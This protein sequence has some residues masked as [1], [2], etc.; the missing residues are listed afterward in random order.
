MKKFIRSFVLLFTVCLL[1]LSFSSVCA[2]PTDPPPV[3]DHGQNG[4]DP[5][6]APIDGGV[7]ILLL[8]G[9]GYAARK[10]YSVKKEKAE[11]VS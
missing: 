4:G 10:L 7:G 3:P 11:V 8:M 1:S 9:A 5:V 2:D 6:G